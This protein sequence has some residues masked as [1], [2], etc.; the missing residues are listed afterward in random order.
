M[1]APS[2][3]K[4]DTLTELKIGSIIKPGTLSVMMLEE[5][6]KLNASSF[7]KR[8]H[9]LATLKMMKSRMIDELGRDQA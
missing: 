7:S 6:Y 2:N 5:M 1:P 8:D 3:G 4:G 9:W